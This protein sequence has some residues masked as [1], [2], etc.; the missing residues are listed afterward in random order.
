MRTEK[1]HACVGRP[2]E[3]ATGIIDGALLAMPC[4]LRSGCLSD[5]KFA[6]ENLAVESL[7]Q[8]VHSQQCLSEEARVEEV[9][10]LV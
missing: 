4:K 8:Q 2:V 6:S 5:S 3:V 1:S 7:G 9:S 10:G